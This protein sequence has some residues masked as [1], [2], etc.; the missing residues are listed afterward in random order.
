MDHAAS[1]SAS[2]VDDVGGGALPRLSRRAWILVA[3]GL[4]L[5]TAGAAWWALTIADAPVRWR[6]VGFEIISPTEA[7]VT[8]D[9]F[10]YD[11]EPVTCTVQALNVRFAEVGVD[12]VVVD[13][14]DGLSQRLTTT[15]VTTEEAN[16][17][18]VHHCE[19]VD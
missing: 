11:E 1:A 19:P 16:T 12:S 14:A 15:L 10:F 4:A 18:T 6:D 5:A 13:P 3:L 17:A 2:D 8:F 7:T 9:V